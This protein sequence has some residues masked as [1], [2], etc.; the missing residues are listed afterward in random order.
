MWHVIE[1]FHDMRISARLIISIGILLVAILTILTI[2]RY[3]EDQEKD[4]GTP[5]AGPSNTSHQSGKLRERRT[6]TAYARLSNRQNVDQAAEAWYNELLA[7]HPELQADYEDVPDSANGFLQ[8]LKL[9][10]SLES[11]ENLPDSKTLEPVLNGSADWNPALV[12]AWI[13]DHREFFNRLREIAELDQQSVNGIPFSRQAR[14]MAP[15][16]SQMSAL[17]RAH[18]RLSLNAGRM[19]DAKRS[20]TAAYN[21]AA[22]LDDIE[23]PSI[24]NKILATNIR[25]N[26]RFRFIHDVAPKLLSEPNQIEA[27]WTA[28]NADSAPNLGLD[29]ALI[30]EWHHTTRNLVL[31]G[32]LESGRENPLRDVRD[33]DTFLAAYA[34]L[35]KR[36]VRAASGWKKPSEIMPPN[37]SADPDLGALDQDLL[38]DYL[39]WN[40][41][42]RGFQAHAVQRVMQDAAIA[43]MLGE[44]PP[45]EPMSGQPFAFNPKTRVLSIPDHPRLKDIAITPLTLP[46]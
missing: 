29:R 39:N 25:N 2:R 9:I 38:R 22:H 23:T 34:D 17:L 33:P 32:M 7:T 41:L 36:R 11:P 5:I 43:I 42:V 1:I 31:P 6:S 30:G 40:G 14:L 16:A 13:S 44:P 20:Y 4:R 10:E 24:F 19:D 8:L 37:L 3:S 28:L 35:T 18:G 21:L 46:R 12:A 26:I 15:F 27:W 45:P